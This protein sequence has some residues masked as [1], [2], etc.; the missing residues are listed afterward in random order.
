MF[1]FKTHDNDEAD[2]NNNSEAE[3]E[4]CTDKEVAHRFWSTSN[5]PHVSAISNK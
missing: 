2:D 5:R 3:F 1:G 4:K